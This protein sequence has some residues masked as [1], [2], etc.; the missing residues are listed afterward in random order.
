[1]GPQSSE[2]ETRLAF[3]P[4][5]RTS[6]PAFSN[7]TWK[8]NQHGVW[9]TLNTPRS[10]DLLKDLRLRRPDTG[11]NHIQIHATDLAQL[12]FAGK[13]KWLIEFPP[14]WRWF[15]TWA[16]EMLPAEFIDHNIWLA[17]GSLSSSPSGL[18]SFGSLPPAGSTLTSAPP[19]NFPS[20]SS[21]RHS[22][23]GS[24]TPSQQSRG[25]GQPGGNPQ[26]RPAQHPIDPWAPLD[27]SRKTLPKLLLP[28]KQAMQH[29]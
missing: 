15:L 27:R 26:P 22:V 24:T 20:L 17:P 16:P 18:S 13:L 9:R 28:S 29:T 11:T 5:S 2:L 1:M 10:Q 8:L 21:L 3:L 7:A 19:V 12:P 14:A 4:G 6:P 25:A 23:Q